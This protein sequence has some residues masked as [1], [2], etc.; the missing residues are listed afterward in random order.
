MTNAIA[1]PSAPLRR[2]AFSVCGPRQVLWL[3]TNAPDAEESS[4]CQPGEAVAR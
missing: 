3:P 4:R 2:L 1:R